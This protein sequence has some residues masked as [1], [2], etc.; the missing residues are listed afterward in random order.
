[1]TDATALQRLMVRERIGRTVPARVLRNS[2]EL[3]I[4]LTLSELEG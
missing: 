4:K 2:A 3:T 1:V